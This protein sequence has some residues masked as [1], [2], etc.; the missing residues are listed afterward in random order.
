[1]IQTQ[2]NGP[3]EYLTAQA[4]AAPHCFTT[5]Y[6]GVSRGHLESLNLGTGRGDDPEN[7]LENYRR[8]G[9]ALGFDIHNVVLPRQ[10]HSDIVL[11][12]TEEHRGAG[13]FTPPLPECDGLI[14]N[15]PGLALVIFTADCTPILFWDSV[16]GAVG[17]AHAGWRGTAKAIVGTAINWNSRVNTVAIKSNNPFRDAICSQPRIPP[18][19]RALNHS[20]SC[21]F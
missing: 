17:A 1:M 11:T 6:G 7:V 4:I 20:T 18:A 5:R 2:K 13:L 14:T 8:L 19:I 3:L 10:T 12:V 15:T 21:F 16:T 9:S